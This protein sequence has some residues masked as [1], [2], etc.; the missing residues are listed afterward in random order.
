MGGKTR[1]NWVVV[2][3][4]SGHG[5]EQGG[6]HSDILRVVQRQLHHRCFRAIYIHYRNH[7]IPEAADRAFESGGY[8]LAKS[9]LHFGTLY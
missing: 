4:L 9:C 5:N 2:A 6:G 1:A 8:P 7:E 3:G